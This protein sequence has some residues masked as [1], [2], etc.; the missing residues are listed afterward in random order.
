MSYF[1]KYRNEGF[2]SSMVVAKDIASVMGV[3]A[4]FPVKRR[5]LRKKLY[6]ENDCCNETNLQGEKD[7]EVNLSGTVIR[8]TPN[9]P[10]HGC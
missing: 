8:G 10:E 6:D 9:T 4:S 2:A 7:F 1:D 3:E 5:A